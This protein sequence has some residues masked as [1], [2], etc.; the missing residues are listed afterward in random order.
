MTGPR[1]E[2]LIDGIVVSVVVGLIGV[3][4]FA[5]SVGLLGGSVPAWSVVLLPLGVGIGLAYEKWLGF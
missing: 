5:L 2:N 1:E 4:C 3:G